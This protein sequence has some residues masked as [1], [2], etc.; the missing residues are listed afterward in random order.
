MARR[1]PL[2][3]IAARFGVFFFFALGAAGCFEYEERLTI[4]PNGSVDAQVEY[5][6]PDWLPAPGGI[7]RA[8]LPRD[9]AGLRAWFGD[10]VEA[11]EDRGRMAFS[12]RFPSPGNLDS[13]F[14]R[15]QLVFGDGGEYTFRVRITIPREYARQITAEV[16]HRV[17]AL[18]LLS[19]KRKDVLS[20]M[21]L[22]KSGFRFHLTLP[23]EL[24][25]APGR[26]N[27]NQVLWQVP[28]AHF[29]RHETATLELRGRLTA[30]ER[31]RRY[32]GW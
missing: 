18:P 28:L 2:L 15:H 9:A 23:G 4:Y 12:A 31:V 17:H 8:E 27:E 29:E 1:Q 25:Y 3:L 30:W 6:L 22:E 16:T 24:L 7:R 13:P 5:V 26:L 10:G 21:A 20:A 32:F 11:R 14:I 19:G